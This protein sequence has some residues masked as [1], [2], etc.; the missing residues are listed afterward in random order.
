[1][2]IHRGRNQDA[3]MESSINGKLLL[4]FF[5][6]LPFVMLVVSISTLLDLKWYWSLIISIVVA[7]LFGKLFATL[8]SSV[9]G[10]KQK[11]DKIV[12]DLGGYPNLHIV[13]AL[14]T[15][16]LGVLLY[17]I[18]IVSIKNIQNNRPSPNDNKLIEYYTEEEDLDE[19][20]FDTDEEYYEKH[21]G[22]YEDIEEED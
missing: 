22:Y 19:S 14:I 21:R 1:M 20:D 9:F 8:Y 12:L 15:F 10:Y 4:L 18:C 5:T 13:D 17:I 2:L 6:L 16:I 3:A 7:I 11:M